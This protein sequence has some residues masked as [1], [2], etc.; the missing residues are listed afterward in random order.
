ML[1]K[2]IIQENIPKQIKYYRKLRHLTQDDLAAD[3]EVSKSTIV[4]WENGSRTPTLDKIFSLC[5]IL[6][7]TT[8]D[9]FGE[10][11]DAIRRKKQERLQRQSV[12]ELEKEM[13]DLLES[14]YKL[15]DYGRSYLRVV[16]AHE[17]HRC[18]D[19]NI[20]RNKREI[21]LDVRLEKRDPNMI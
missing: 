12:Y 17:I 16:L 4:M 7:C 20:L 15:D 8:E 1:I 3:L 9:L 14:Y 10:T 21:Y 2:T 19:L 13:T 11:E 18:A 6:M 5:N